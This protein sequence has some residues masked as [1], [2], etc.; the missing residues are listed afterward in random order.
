VF[1]FEC[2]G[3]VNA[4][5]VGGGSGGVPFTDYIEAG[6]DAATNAKNKA[7][8]TRKIPAGPGWI[9]KYLEKEFPDCDND[10]PVCSPCI[11][12]HE[13]KYNRKWETTRSSS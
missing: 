10:T 5:R 12:E 4:C 7:N 9:A 11:E 3:P 13:T 1:F 2:L 8:K 6:R